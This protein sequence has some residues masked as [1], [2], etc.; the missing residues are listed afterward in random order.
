MDTIARTPKQ[1]GSGIRRFRRQKGLTQGSLGEAMHARQATVSK[2][3]SGEPATQLRI[4]M[5]ALTA[6]DLELVIRPRTKVSTQE[7]ENLF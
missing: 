4:L 2:L 1:L 7:I 6:L 5:D 3:E